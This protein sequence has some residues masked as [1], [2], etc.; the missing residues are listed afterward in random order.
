M[1]IFSGFHKMEAESTEELIGKEHD[2]REHLLSQV[3]LVKR[4]CAV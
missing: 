3:C 4:F 1:K 2:Y